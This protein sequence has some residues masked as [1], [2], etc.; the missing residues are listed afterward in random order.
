MRWCF[1]SYILV[2][3]CVKDRQ[4]EAEA[5]TLCAGYRCTYRCDNGSALNE[6]LPFKCL[7]GLYM[8]ECTA[9]YDCASYQICYKGVCSLT[10]PHCASNQ[11]QVLIH[12]FNSRMLE[13][14][15]LGRNNQMSDL[16]QWLPSFITRYRNT[17]NSKYGKMSGWHADKSF[18]WIGIWSGQWVL[19]NR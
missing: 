4:C 5:N 8:P 3:D 19:T 6:T 15:T 17:F 11:V 1:L 7:H 9:D 2:T 14:I 10:C 18:Y 13:R 12:L 16:K